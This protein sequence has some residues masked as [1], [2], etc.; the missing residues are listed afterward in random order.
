MPITLPKALP[1]GKVISNWPLFALASAAALT[2]EA[3]TFVLLWTYEPDHVVGV[4]YSTLTASFSLLGLVVSRAAAQRRADPRPE[5]QRS[6]FA[7]RVVSLVLILPSVFIGGG[8]M[9]LKM[10]D[11]AAIE[12]A[13]SDAF[14]AAKHDSTDN[15]LDSQVRRDAGA[16]LER[17]IRP[18]QVRMDDAAYF[19]S[20]LAYLAVLMLPV[21]AIGA[22]VAPKPETAGERKRRLDGVK[23]AKA[24]ATREANK[25]AKERIERRLK[26]GKSP[27]VVDL[28]RRTN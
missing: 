2:A 12:Y 11:R 8:A 21:I 13:G 3:L 28:V 25:K 4:L 27:N 15:T 9:A 5:V 17:A 19:G 16:E 26:S 10:E 23:A 22:G 14:R 1:K 7:A 6:A 18:T 24:A 20:V